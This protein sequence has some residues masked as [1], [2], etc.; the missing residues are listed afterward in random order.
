MTSISAFAD[1]Y[2]TPVDAARRPVADALA[3]AVAA[4]AAKLA[5]ASR[6]S[7]YAVLGVSEQVDD[8]QL[9][10]AY[11]ARVQALHPDQYHA[12]G[13]HAATVAMLSQQLAAVNA[14]YT[15]IVAQRAKKFA[16]LGRVFAP[17]TQRSARRAA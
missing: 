16:G 3:E 12:A 2:S 7:P 1:A 11:L 5:A 17:R 6:Q 8:V 14:A 15:G 10:R 13:A 4:L 9:R